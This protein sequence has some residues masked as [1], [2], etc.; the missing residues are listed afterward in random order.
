MPKLTKEQ[1]W[2]LLPPVRDLVI[3]GKAYR[4]IGGKSKTAAQERDFVRGFNACRSLIIK[5]LNKYAA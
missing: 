5:R 1:I 4:V 3:G 2:E